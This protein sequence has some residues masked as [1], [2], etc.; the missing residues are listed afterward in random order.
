MRSQRPALRSNEGFTFIE[1]MV[2]LALIATIAVIAMPQLLPAVIYSTHEG[3]ARHLANY[4]RSAIGHASLT[5]SSVT[6]MIDLKEQQYWCEALPEPE[7]DEDEE[8]DMLG[9]DE[10]EFPEDDDELYRMAQEELNK[11]EDERDSEEGD[12]LIDEQRER[13]S[14]AFNDRSRRTLEARADRVNH[15]QQGILQGMGDLFDEEFELDEDGEEIVPEELTDP[16]LQRTRLPDG[17]WI[18]VIEVAEVEQTED[19]VEIEISPLGLGSDVVF[20][21]MNEDGETLRVAWDPVT[22]NATIAEKKEE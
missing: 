2:V 6:I 20:L 1:L 8:D 16:L 18:D 9:G 19:I 15:D 7:P 5:R 11:P 10:K 17:V 22:G 14:T 4:G 12:E 21:L 3:A 13:M